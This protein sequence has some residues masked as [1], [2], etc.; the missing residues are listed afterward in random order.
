MFSSSPADIKPF[1]L[2]D[3]MDIIRAIELEL[4]V[5]FG[6]KDIFISVEAAGFQSNMQVIAKLTKKDEEIDLPVSERLRNLLLRLREIRVD[7]DSSSDALPWYT[8]TLTG[9]PNFR[10]NFRYNY[11][12]NP[13]EMGFKISG[14]DLF[15]D[16]VNFP[17]DLEKLPKW[18]LEHL[19]LA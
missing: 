18:F 15:L 1:D 16:L 6:E 2:Y 13:E 9:A 17:R 8:F 11:S 14:D 4:W 10:S 5:F 3:E 12:R 7:N 19:D